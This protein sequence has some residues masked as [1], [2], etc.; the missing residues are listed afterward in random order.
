ML[1]EEEEDYKAERKEYGPSPAVSG[2]RLVNEKEDK[3]IHSEPS[4]LQFKTDPIKTKI[5][6][7]KDV[8]STRLDDEDTLERV[9][10]YLQEHAEIMMGNILISLYKARE[11]TMC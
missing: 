6:D 8:Q 1:D 3:E 11:E 7:E 5:L 4:T 10:Y 2:G 9:R